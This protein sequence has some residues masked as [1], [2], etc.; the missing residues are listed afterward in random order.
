[1][2]SISGWISSKPLDR[3]TARK[4]CKALIY[5]GATRGQQ[6]A[7]IYINGKVIKQAITPGNFI[8]T[9]EFFN[10]F[11]VEPSM[12]L[13]HTRQ[14]TC[15]G[16]GDAQ[17]QPFQIGDTVTVHN[18]FYFDTKS[19]KDTWSIKKESGVDSE[20][21][22]SFVETYGIHL[23]PEFLESTDG[24]SAVGCLHQGSLYL[25]KHGNPIALLSMVL[26]E[27]IKLTVFASTADI[28][29]DALKYCW[30]MP[31][32]LKAS[33]IKESRLFHVTPYGIT[34]LGKGIKPYTSQYTYTGFES[35]DWWKDRLGGGMRGKWNH[36]KWGGPR[37]APNDKKSRQADKGSPPQTK[38]DPLE[39]KV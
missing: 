39:S 16:F 24:P 20:L 3:S 14:P 2:C 37:T 11:E 13:M 30:L 29:N 18:G 36:K 17:A 31:S 5:Y 25:V 33:Q 19:L 28:V 35:D 4:L 27:S 7:G 22:T 10:A 6:S 9:S 12:A 26:G 8:D 15:G 1:M 32:S 34:A 23:L 21:V 38:M